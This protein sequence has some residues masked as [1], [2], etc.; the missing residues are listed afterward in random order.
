[1]EQTLNDFI[2]F[3]KLNKAGEFQAALVSDGFHTFAELYAYRMAYNAALFNEF[4]S[5]GKYEVHK[6]RCHEDGL[7]CFGGG[8]FVVVA[9]LP[10]GQITN[11]YPL[12]DWDHFRIPERE[13]ANPWD[14]HTPAV[15]LQRLLALGKEEADA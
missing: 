5:A 8:W 13:R 14:G 1:M 12:A 15:A 2:Q 7:P 10:T 9:E 11:H 4:A 3:L 6:S